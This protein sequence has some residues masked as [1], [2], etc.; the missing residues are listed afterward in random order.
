MIAVVPVMGKSEEELRKMWVDVPLEYRMNKNAHYVP[1]E[2]GKQNEMIDSTLADGW[3]GVAMNVTF[4]QYLTEKGMLG[5]KQ[6]CEMAK[7]KGMDLWMYDEQGY[8]SGNAGGRVIA[9]NPSWES[10]GIYFTD[11]NT[12]GGKVEFDMPPGEIV[13]VSAFPIRNGEADLGAGINLQNNV[14]GGKLKWEAPKG[15]W[16]VF[17]ATKYSLHEGFQ[18]ERNKPH[19]PSLMIP[20]ATDAF[21]RI[22]HDRYAEFM[23]KDLGRYFTSTFTDEPSTM[24]VQFH[25][26]KYKHAVIPWQEI[27]SA[28]MARKYGY[29]PE[30][31]LAELFYDKGAVGKRVRYQYF[32]TVGDLMAENY[33]G[34]IQ[35]WCRKHNTRSGGHL[36]LEESMIA[37]TTLY[38]NIM[39]CFRKMDAPGID[40]L[41]CYPENLYVHS[42]KLA[43]SAAELMGNSRVMSEPC[44]VA[45][46]PDEPEVE[47]VRGHL[48]LLLQSGVTDFN[49]YLKLE[50]FGR[51]QKIEINK[52]VGRIG[53]LLRGGYCAAE[54]GVIYPIESMW[55][56][57]RPRYHKVG[58]WR[59]VLGAVAEVN[60]IENDFRNVSRF[61]FENRWEY[62]HLDSQAL[63]ESEI[64]DGEMVHGKLRF[65]VLVLPDVDTLEMKAWSQLLKFVKRGGKIVFMGKKPANTDINFPD[66]NLQRTFEKFIQSSS[67]VVYMDSLDGDKLDGLLE[68]WLGRPVAFDDEKLP[69]RLAYKVVDGSKVYFLVNDS[70]EEIETGAKFG[71]DGN[72]EEWDPA[73]G[74]VRPV[75][76]SSNIVL[77]PYSG[78]VYRERK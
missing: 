8:P 58:G 76:N 71:I 47:Y 54:V 77:K 46:K 34:R 18:A 2:A 28:E 3:G 67:N 72:L 41:S 16:Q 39:Q 73:S 49:C 53:M 27:L 44:P 64:E 25:S 45:D 56:E 13:Q 5:T 43:S 20:E 23:G 69:I 11:T 78:K 7:D 48:N 26:Y 61:M 12:D 63:I 74:E 55:T 68:K 51:E 22:T 15:K 37:H 52:Y 33:F 59:H 6:F 30:E 70:K 14:E 29:R 31:K 32:K 75:S 4:H 24:A 21:L 60:K 65:K 10:K 57:F 66:G 38:G 17:A 1:L 35:D 50:K 40:I 42:P 36:L 19:Y 62:L 9:E